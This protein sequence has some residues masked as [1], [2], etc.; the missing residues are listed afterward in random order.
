MRCYN[1]GLA[2]AFMDHCARAGE[3]A[4]RV[5]RNTDYFVLHTPFR[6]MPGSA[7]EALLKTVL[8][9]DAERAREFLT[10]KSFDV[11]LDP[12]ARIGNLYT[13]SL[14]ASLAFL[15]SDRLKALGRGIIGKRLL[16]ASYGSGNTMVVVAG[17]IAAGAAEVVSRWDP[18]RVESSARAASFEEYEAWTTGPVQPELQARLMENARV[19]PGSFMLSGIRKDGYR[20]YKFSKAAEIGAKSEEREAPDDLHGSVAISG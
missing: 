13:G 3:K 11:A 5:L 15:L 9:L 10:E 19:P 16:L 6:N 14:T 17:R 18:A 1:E 8:G 4:E 20:E 12:L 7:M 2:G